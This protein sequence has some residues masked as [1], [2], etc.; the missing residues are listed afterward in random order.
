M[1]Y[2]KP[3]PYTDPP[4]HEVKVIQRDIAKY[5]KHRKIYFDKPDSQNCKGKP[6]FVLCYRGMYVGMETKRPFGYGKVTKLQE[7]RHKEIRE[8][9]GFAFV[10][11]CVDDVELYLKLVDKHIMEM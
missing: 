7:L 8:S 10:V 9:D 1:M 6:D 3:K 4:P 5:L 11:Y 2:K